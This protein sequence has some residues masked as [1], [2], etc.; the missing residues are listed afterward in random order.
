M[1]LSL[2]KSNLIFLKKCL[3]KWVHFMIFGSLYLEGAK[4]MDAKAFL[5]PADLAMMERKSLV[6]IQKR[7]GAQ[8]VTRLWWTH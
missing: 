8:A 2:P 4:G 5:T 3:D 1:G 7:G 6:N